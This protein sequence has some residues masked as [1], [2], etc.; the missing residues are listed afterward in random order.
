MRYQIYNTKSHSIVEEIELKDGEGI[1]HRRFTGLYDKHDVPVYEGDVLE[2]KMWKVY[3]V[4]NG[5]RRKIVRW[6]ESAN[7]I[8]FNVSKAHELEVIGN[9]WENPTLKDV[10]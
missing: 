5:Y 10:C 6:V 3:G 4:R 8:G 1:V 7:K 2:R 9:I